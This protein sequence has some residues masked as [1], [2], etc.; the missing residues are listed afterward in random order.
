MRNR[1]RGPGKPDGETDPD[2]LRM[3]EETATAVRLQQ[4]FDRPIAGQ[5][6]YDHMKAIHRHIFQD[7]YDWA[8]QER[9]GP[10]G[11]MTKNGHKYYPAGQTLTQAAEA[12]YAKLAAKNHLRGLDKNRFVG[13]LAESWGEINVIHS[14]REGNTR[15]QFAFFTQ[16][17]EQAGYRIDVRRFAPGAPLRQA[18]IDARFHSQDTGSNDRLAAVLNQAV[19]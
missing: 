14:F 19:S 8:G 10:S 4:L 5:F 13:E 2:K 16:L 9:V 15:S 6:D 7:V 17:A 12:E 3:L 18:F 11:F 1:F